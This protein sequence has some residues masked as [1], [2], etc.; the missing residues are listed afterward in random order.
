MQW[1]NTE[2]A[3]F[4]S[5]KPWLAVNP[6]YKNINV[7]NDQKNEESILNFYK[8]MIQ[9]RKNELGLVYGYFQPLLEEDLEVF[10]YKR[11]LENN[12]FIILLNFSSNNIYRKFESLEKYEILI[13]NYK[14]HQID[15]KGLKLK[16][17]E[18]IIFKK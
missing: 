10:A 2:H 17:Y 16:P 6:S 12:E 5:G 14:D 11:I 8:K 1:D 13:S 18:G 15:K 4:T 3:G 9:T 7:S